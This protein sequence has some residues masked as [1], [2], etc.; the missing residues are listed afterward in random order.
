MCQVGTYINTMF[1][2][3]SS[4]TVSVVKEYEIN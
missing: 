2:G 1:W 3:S 4:G